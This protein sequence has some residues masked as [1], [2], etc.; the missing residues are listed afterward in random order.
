MCKLR[1]I[2]SEV[3]PYAQ[4]AH[5]CLLEKAADF[6]VVEV[7]L[8]DKPDWFEKIS[9]YSKVPVLQHGQLI[10]YESTIINEYL[11]E[12]IPQP[13]LM[14]KQ[15]ADRAVA[16]IW[17]DFDNVK[18]VPLFY[19]VLLEQDSA[20]QQDLVDQIVDHFECFER[21]GLADD[22][23]GPYWFGKD[24]SL[25]DIAIYPHFERLGVLQAYRKIEIPAACTKLREWHAAMRERASSKHTAHDD[26]YHIKAYKKY[27]EDTAQ[28]NT[29]K[30][31]RQP[32]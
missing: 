13:M 7:D 24:V 1:L 28:G 21:D 16:R 22:R 2:Q 9:P 8:A 27:A 10:V 6:D 32:A 11:E 12:V 29:A 25:V 20:K 18:F 4:R 5:M 23:D 14:P 19:R 17:I 3:C 26:A 31:M 30:E 15:P